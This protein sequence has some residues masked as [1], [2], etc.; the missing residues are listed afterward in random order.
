[1][2]SGQVMVIA[3]C[4]FFSHFILYTD[5]TRIIRT[6]DL[7]IIT[8][9]Q[10]AVLVIF[11]ESYF[12]RS[13][14]LNFLRKIN[15]I[16]FVLEYKLGITSKYSVQKRF[17]LRQFIQWI[18]LNILTFAVNILVMK[19]NM[20]RWWIIL[21]SSFFICSARYFQIT[22]FAAIIHKKFHQ[23]NQ[24]VTNLRPNEGFNGL[25]D[26]VK[27]SIS[28]RFTINEKYQSRCIYDKLSDLRNL[29]R[30]LS[31]ANRALN[32]M[33]QWSL[34]IMIASEFL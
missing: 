13:I 26:L 34:Q 16:D 6:L 15:T 10:F 8:L 3:L 12:K 21:Y 24:V 27:V 1:M 5:G 9:T 28:C 33:F 20:Y 11:I 17:L 30:L 29:C 22:T 19:S 18:F 32:Q 25:D 4:L 31:S 23:M 14:Q 7:T 2:I